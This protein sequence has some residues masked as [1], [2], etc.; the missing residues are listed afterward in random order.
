LAACT[1][2]VTLRRG[3]INADRYIRECLKEHVVPFAAIVHDNA[4]PHIAQIMR[5]YLHDVGIQLLRRPPMSPDLNPIEHRWDN[6][7]RSMRQNYGEFHTVVQLE[8]APLHEW[9]MIPQD[10]VALITSMPGRLR[11][12]IQARGGNT[13]Y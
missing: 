8:Q 11:A 6:L 1:A 4:R 10:E 12:V 9:E 13:R 7:G 3:S 5:Q 2:L